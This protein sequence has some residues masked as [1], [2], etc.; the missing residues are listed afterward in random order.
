LTALFANERKHNRQRILQCIDIEYPHSFYQIF[1]EDRP[2]SIPPSPQLALYYMSL[3]F[4][5]IMILAHAEEQSVKNAAPE[6]PGAV[7]DE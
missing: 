3:L 2:K 7:R 1:D 5:L 4:L 6:S